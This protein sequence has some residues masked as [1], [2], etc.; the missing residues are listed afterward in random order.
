MESSP[1]NQPNTADLWPDPR[2]IISELKRVPVFR[3]EDML[4]RGLKPFVQDQARRMNCPMESIAVSL[5]CS[6][7]TVIGT[8]CVIAPKAKDD[9][10]VALN[11]WGAVVGPPSAK[12]TPALSAGISFLKRLQ[13]IENERIGREMPAF[14]AEKAAFEAKEAALKLLL[15]SKAMENEEEVHSIQRELQALTECAPKQPM[16]RRFMTNDATIE[17]IGDILQ[18]NSLGIMNY[19]DELAGL[20]SSWTRPGHEG[21]KAFYLEG[22]NGLDCY[23]V[24]RIGRGSFIIPKH[25]LSLLGGMQ[26]DKLAA[27]LKEA[28]YELGNDGLLQ[29][30]QMLVYPDPCQWEYTDNPPD[31]KARERVA[32]INEKLAVM[33]PG[34]LGALPPDDPDKSWYY[35]F[36]E[37]AQEY[38]IKWYSHLHQVKIPAEDDP[39]MAQHLQKYDKLFPMLSLV[40]HLVNIVDEGG[41]GGP[42]TLEAAVMAGEWCEFLEAHARR[43]YGLVL[44]QEFKAAQELASMLLNDVLEDGFTARMVRRSERSRLKKG[45]LVQAAIDWLC[46]EG[47]LKPVAVN[48]CARQVGRPTYMYFINPKIERFRGRHR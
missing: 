40:F 29:R 12:K 25:C 31:T 32:Q 2:P 35:R 16:A 15:R 5:I 6:L 9:W 1:L 46:E 45:E 26:P 13:K 44:D 10:L 27:Y 19:R 7:G 17:K 11:V 18:Y 38:F 28:R 37:M 4:P 23:H 3:V 30:L 39:M 36:N 24:D 42:V 34:D 20:M 48:G 22:Y 8:R 43:C 47:W 41:C 33:V 21:D 14:L